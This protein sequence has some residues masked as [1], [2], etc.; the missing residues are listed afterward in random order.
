MVN[1]ERLVLGISDTTRGTL[2]L[3]L[4]QVR[5]TPIHGSPQP[6]Y[7]PRRPGKPLSPSPSAALS[8][9]QRSREMDTKELIRG[10]YEYGQPRE[11]RYRTGA[12]ECVSARLTV[13]VAAVIAGAEGSEK[14]SGPGRGNGNSPR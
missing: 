13:C 10:A 9:S 1:G 2:L 6:L 11:R 5:A 12:Q 3:Q 14:C 7:L 8:T 4:S